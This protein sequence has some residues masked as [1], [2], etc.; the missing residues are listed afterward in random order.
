M[1]EI[2]PERL[3]GFVPNAHGRRDWSLAET[4]FKV[5]VNFG[6]LRG[7]RAVYVWK[8]IFAVVCHLILSGDWYIILFAGGL[9]QRHCRKKPAKQKL[10]CLC[11]GVL[12]TLYSSV[13]SLS[14]FLFT[15]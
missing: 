2:S 10:W 13:I 15:A 3:N 9:S 14:D 8:N 6:G 11:E 5:K 1:Y 7:L 12:F 4:S